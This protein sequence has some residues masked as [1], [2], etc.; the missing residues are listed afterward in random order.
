VTP[1][2]TNAYRRYL[3]YHN[4]LTA[5]STVINDLYPADNDLVSAMMNLRGYQV[6]N[7]SA[8]A[9]LDELASG[10]RHGWY[11]ELLMVQTARVDEVFPFAVPWSMVQAYY[12]IYR[13]LAAYFMVSNERIP[14]SH[15]S[16]L[17]AIA[18]DLRAAHAP[19]P[20]PWCTTLSGDPGEKQAQLTCC[21]YDQPITLT[22]PMISNVD[23]W[24][25]VGLMLRTTRKRTLEEAVQGWKKREKKNR[26]RFS[27]KQAIINRMMPTTVFDA[28]Y[29]MRRRSNYQD[30]DS[31]IFS[32]V[33]VAETLNL[34]L[35]LLD[36]VHASLLVFECLIAK[37]T[38]EGWM[39]D[40]V[41]EFVNANGDAANG[42]IG[43]RW[44]TLSS[45]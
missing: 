19:F 44:E 39:D 41:G 2:R 38:P 25:N 26:I 33:N 42:T 4:Y 17:R 6:F 34:H 23:A 3:A 7:R 21:P 24:Q 20:A 16:T 35:A 31:F 9:D 11:T 8:L 14:T 15:N 10:L 40:V 22:N 45:V 30:S 29:R 1:D 37:V 5:L 12:A 18:N 13:G 32:G 36:I 28:F 43:S 27:E